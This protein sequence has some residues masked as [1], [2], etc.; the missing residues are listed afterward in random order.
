M[1]AA[2][3][4]V[5]ALAEGHNDAGRE[6]VSTVERPVSELKPET[7]QTDGTM[8]RASKGNKV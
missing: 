2:V 5:R 4:A 8:R 1:A 3:P 6:R 7:K